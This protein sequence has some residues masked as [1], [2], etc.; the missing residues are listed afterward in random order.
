MG[1]FVS[2]KSYGKGHLCH[3]PSPGTQKAGDGG[4]EFWSSLYLLGAQGLGKFNVVTAHLSIVITFCPK[5]LRSVLTSPFTEN[6]KGAQTSA[7]NVPSGI[8]IQA[9]QTLR[10]APRGLGAQTGC[11]REMALSSLPHSSLAFHISVLPCSPHAFPPSKPQWHLWAAQCLL[12]C[13]QFAV[14]NWDKT[15]LYTGPTKEDSG[16]VL[17]KYIGHSPFSARKSSLKAL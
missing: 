12:H 3:K 9:W 16:N 1:A 4:A 13:T 10:P 14:F 2:S 17:Q 8:W 7:Q 5:S 15:S 6:K 11:G